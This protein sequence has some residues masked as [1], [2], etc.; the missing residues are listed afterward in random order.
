MAQIRRPDHLP[1]VRLRRP[2]KLN[3]KSH[4]PDTCYRPTEINVGRQTMEKEIAKLNHENFDSK[5]IAI[6]QQYNLM[7][8][9]DSKEATKIVFAIFCKFSWRDRF[10][11]P[12]V[13]KFFLEMAA[14]ETEKSEYTLLSQLEST[15]DSLLGVLTLLGQ[16]TALQCGAITLLSNLSR[17]T[18]LPLEHREAVI[19][20]LIDI[21]KAFWPYFTEDT[22]YYWDSNIF[23]DALCDVLKTV[24]KLLEE[25][26]P[27][28]SE[29]TFVMINKLVIYGTVS[30]YSRLRLLEVKD[31]QS[32]NWH[33]SEDSEEYYRDRYFEV[34][35]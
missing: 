11:E 21:G 34:S 5:T 15:C 30:A 4:D 12:L 28:N 13:A 32:Y 7:L 6:I 25:Q 27:V 10:Q 31:R 3:E 17:V 29:R 22:P 1:G 35:N 24:G 33:L 19:C 9:E 20:Y 23:C 16:P 18:S 8:V 2:V 26:Y 14:H